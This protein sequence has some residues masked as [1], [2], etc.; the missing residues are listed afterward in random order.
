VAQPLA[1]AGG[2]GVIPAAA[3]AAV[4]GAATGEG[5]RVDALAGGLLNR[6]FRIVTAAGEFVLRLNAAPRDAAQLGV[7]RRA[8]LT[9]QRLAAAAGL[10]PRVVAAADDH[11]W[12]VSEFVAGEVAD[13]AALS[14]PRGL[15]RVGTT[16][17]RLRGVDVDGAIDGWT[18]PVGPSLIERARALVARAIQ[19]LPGESAVLAA[20]LERAECGWRAA[21]VQSRRAACLV[22]SDPGPGNVLLPPGAGAA[23]LLDWEYAH[24]GDPL[25][26]PAALLHCCPALRG[27]EARLL[28]ACGL[29]GQADVAMLAGMAQ[30]YAAIDAA[31]SQL[32]A[33]A[34]G[35]PPGGRAN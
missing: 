10:A 32:A 17:A 13:A 22:H 34:A 23:L 6:S 27:Q 8:E 18:L 5:V 31:W 29:A 33:T 11:S 24:R 25:Q 35:V 4:P 9:A 3:L 2:A 19:R 1:T 26:D 12:Q 21:G 28:Q 15:A 14:T 16:L 30:V 7:D 20:L